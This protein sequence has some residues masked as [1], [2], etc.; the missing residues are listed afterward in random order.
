MK[1]SGFDNS[2]PGTCMKQDNNPPAEEIR[3]DKWLW[4]ARF[5]KTRSLA[6]TAV[7]GGKIKVNGGRIKP[8]RTVKIGDQLHIERGDIAF[9]ITIEEL[10]DKRGPAKQAVLLYRE[11]D[12]SIMKREEMAQARR[13]EKRSAVRYGG[14]PDKK[15]RRNLRKLQGKIE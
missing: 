13:L 15:G 14:R 12:E 2:E 10:S 7:K 1:L 5:F 6:A 8:S 11:S 3:I 9:D 4:A